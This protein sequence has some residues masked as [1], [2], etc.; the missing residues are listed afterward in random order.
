MKIR[1]S[2]IAFAMS[3]LFVIGC[4]GTPVA[5]NRYGNVQP[6]VQINQPQREISTVAEFEEGT[7]ELPYNMNSFITLFNFNGSWSRQTPLTFNLPYNQDGSLTLFN[8]GNTQFKLG[9]MTDGRLWG[10]GF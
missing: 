5:V 8:F 9:P 4:A 3:A 7:F 6:A 1:I 10:L 2:T